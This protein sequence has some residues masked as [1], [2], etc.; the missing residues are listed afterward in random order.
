MTVGS[1]M[2]LGIGCGCNPKVDGLNVDGLCEEEEVEDVLTFVLGIVEGLRKGAF[3]LFF[4]V[5]FEGTREG[6]LN[7]RLEALTNPVACFTCGLLFEDVED[8]LVKPLLYLFESVEAVV[9]FFCVGSFFVSFFG[10]APKNPVNV[11]CLP[12]LLLLNSGFLGMVTPFVPRQFTFLFFRYK[13]TLPH[14][15]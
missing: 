10:L 3:D 4:C 9:D 2:F 1:S 5:F 7:G 8:A 12:L 6:A 11:P 15:F 13:L 14:R